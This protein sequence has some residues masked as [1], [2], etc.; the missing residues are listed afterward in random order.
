MHN[1]EHKYLVNE[2]FTSIEGEG[3]RAGLICTFIRLYGCNLN[4]SYCDSGY[5]CEGDEFT[6]MTLEQIVERVRELGAPLVTLTGGE[7]LIH[8][9]VL[10]LVE[11][12]VADG[13]SINI[14]TNGSQEIDPYVNMRYVM[15]TLDYK[16]HSSEMTPFM[17]THNIQKLRDT[18]VLKFVVGSQEDLE[19]MAEIVFAHHDQANVFVSPVFGKIEPSEIVSFLIKRRL[20]KCR[21]QIQMHKIIW[22]PELRGV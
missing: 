5:A 10:E 15:V 22:P 9:G 12:L 8:D 19:Q 2:I 21:T 14:E 20:Y 11:T 1:D 17:L 13:F 18:D 4:C 6:P 3:I 7:P 16:S